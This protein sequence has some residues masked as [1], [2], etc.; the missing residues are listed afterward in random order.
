MVARALRQIPTR[1]INEIIHDF[2]WPQY[3]TSLSNIRYCTFL[4]YRFSIYFLCCSPVTGLSPESSEGSAFLH[5]SG[6]CGEFAVAT[7]SWSRP[8]SKIHWK[9]LLRWVP[10]ETRLARLPGDVSIYHHQYHLKSNHQYHNNMHEIRYI[11]LIPGWKGEW[12]SWS[13][14]QQ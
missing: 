6:C 12:H 14:A 9:T 1:L 11:L 5:L 7:C 3:L 8:T 10:F 2:F 13:K 4:F